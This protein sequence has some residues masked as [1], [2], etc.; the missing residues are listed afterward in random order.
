METL[1]LVAIKRGFRNLQVRVSIPPAMI[2]RGEKLGI[3]RPGIDPEVGI[4]LLLGPM[5]YRHIFVQRLGHSAPKD[6]EVQVA[7]AFLRA[8][9]NPH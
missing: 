9:K 1:S 7:D 4:A 3:L 8:F 5:I 2:K 6:L